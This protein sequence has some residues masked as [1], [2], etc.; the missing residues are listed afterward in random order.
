MRFGREAGADI[1][2]RDYT[3]TETLLTVSV[4][5]DDE[6][7]LRERLAKILTLRFIP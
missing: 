2:A 3:A 5:L 4:R 1:T 6:A 7:K